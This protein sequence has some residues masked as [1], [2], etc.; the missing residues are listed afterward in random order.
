MGRIFTTMSLQRYPLLFDIQHDHTLKQLNFGV[1]PTA[2]CRSHP[3]NRTQAFKL[4]SRLT[5]LMFIVSLFACEISV[6]I[7]EN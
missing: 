6:K 3:E 5:C 2:G 1:C 4:K 7:V